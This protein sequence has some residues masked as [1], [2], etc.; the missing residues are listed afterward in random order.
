MI[1]LSQ[2]GVS[3]KQIT[4]HT[5]SGPVQVSHSANIDFGGRS[6][7][8]FHRIQRM[9]TRLNLDRI[10]EALDFTYAITDFQHLK[11]TERVKD[12]EDWL[13]DD[14]AS[15]GYEVF[16]QKQPALFLNTPAGRLHM[17]LN[18]TKLTR[19]CTRSTP[20]EVRDA[21][22]QMD[23]GSTAYVANNPSASGSGG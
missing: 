8:T 14:E 15:K 20:L 9:A 6:A 3:A 2:T 19:Q 4:K 12:R 16:G 23:A 11:F 22:N 13:E 5:P 1:S 10:H 18:R 21:M 7:R 17:R